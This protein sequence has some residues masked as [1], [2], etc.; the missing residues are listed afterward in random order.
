MNIEAYISSGILEQ[1][2]LGLLTESEAREVEQVVA[3]YPEV[4]AELNAMED[5]LT[6]YA[7]AKGISMPEDLP[8]RIIRR[9]ETLDQ[10]DQPSDNGKTKPGSGGSSMLPF[11]GVLLFAAIA[12][13]LFL[14][15]RNDRIQGDLEQSQNDLQQLQVQCDTVQQNL[16]QLQLQL[17]ILRSEGNQTFIMRG[18]PNNP[19]AIANVYYNSQTQSAYLDIRELPAPPPG[20][21]YQLWGIGADGVPQSM[22]VFTIPAGDEPVFLQVP[23][24]ADV[25]TFAVSL[26]PQGGSA[27]PT[28]VHLIS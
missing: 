5:A 28:A 9:L 12:G 17:D 8:A 1:Y 18:T 6:Q 15:F 23:F 25:A 20:Q 11:L 22:D 10:S 4:K 21:Q 2:L 26:E 27:T 7:V 14:W 16:D 13:A 19:G 24:L 3:A